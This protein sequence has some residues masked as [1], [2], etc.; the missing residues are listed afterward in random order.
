[1]IRNNAALLAPAAVAYLREDSLFAD[2]FELLEADHLTGQTLREIVDFLDGQDTSHPF[3]F[4]QWAG[5]K[6]GGFPAGTH[7]ALLREHGEIRW[8]AGCSTLYPAGRIFPFVR[9]LIVT[10]G[11]VG[12]I[13]AWRTALP[14]LIE[15]ARDACFSYVE[16]SP[17]ADQSSA[18]ELGQLFN[19]NGWKTS[20]DYRS[21]LR[22]NLNRSLDSILAGFR[23]STRYEVLRAERM[24]VD[25][26]NS[27]RDCDVSQFMQ[28]YTGLAVRKG[29]SPDSPEDL[30]RVLD[31]LS[32][33][34]NRG[35]LLL[36]R[37]QGK[38]AGGAIVVRAGR[39]CWYVWG[40]NQS[41]EG[42]SVGHLLQWR[43]IQWAKGQGCIEYDFGGFRENA[44]S[45]TALFKRGFGGEVV[46]F[47]SPQRNTL[48]RP[49]SQLA[50]VISTIK[51]GLWR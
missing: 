39:R 28:I 33:E 50:R 32:T 20:L 29:F 22:L 1:M 42:F 27:S 31:W 14:A 13:A 12:D 38:I 21:S 41:N 44:V 51:L 16:V 26:E 45:G 8:F 15:K 23:K 19:S 4:P 36:A 9:A 48:R 37:Y 6:S 49:H 43:A 30:R 7:F 18:G 10:R 46:R 34:P 40:A 5:L 25:V 2:G 3:Q 35:A 24:G 17:E 11:P 47:L